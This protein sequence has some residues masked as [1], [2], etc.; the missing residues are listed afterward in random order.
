MTTSNQ[1]SNLIQQAPYTTLSE[2]QAAQIQGGIGIQVWLSTAP[3]SGTGNSTAAAPG[4]R[5]DNP[6]TDKI[7]TKDDY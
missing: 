4:L 6:Y 2:E 1:T 5:Y 7:E 3:D